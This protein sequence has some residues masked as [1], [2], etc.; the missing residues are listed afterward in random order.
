MADNIINPNDIAEKGTESANDFVVAEQP[1]EALT[2]RFSGL[3]SADGEENPG[4]SQKGLRAPVQFSE[5]EQNND[6]LP[7]VQNIE[8]SEQAEF[9]QSQDV[10]K[11]SAEVTEQDYVGNDL[12]GEAE[13]VPF[14]NGTVL[15][16]N[17][18]SVPEGT[19]GDKIL[20]GMQGVRERVE[21]GA[22]QVESNL[23]PASEVMS[24]REMFQTQWTMSNLMIT[25]DY[26]GKVVSK[27]TQAFD[28]L[29]R[30]Q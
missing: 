5:L 11:Q 24:M 7:P 4:N 1:D 18:E 20:R 3:L 6:G 26:I 21:N 15:G 10:F 13:P 28:T 8:N 30:N 27:G 9:K 12:W 23:Q 16:E 2:E 29:L 17:I 22:R 25:E 19:L 14:G